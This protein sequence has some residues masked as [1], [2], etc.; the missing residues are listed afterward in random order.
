[1][2][3]KFLGVEFGLVFMDIPFILSDQ[4]ALSV[5]ETVYWLCDLYTILRVS[6]WISSPCSPE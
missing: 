4:S 6:R 3:T 2:V 5:S 1:M